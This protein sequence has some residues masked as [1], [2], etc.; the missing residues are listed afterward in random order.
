MYDKPCPLEKVY[1]NV[2]LGCR[3]ACIGRR[4][5]SIF[6]QR[7]QK[8]SVC[9]PAL[10]WK[11]MRYLFERKTGASW[12]VRASAEY[13]SLPSPSRVCVTLSLSP[14]GEMEVG[15]AGIVDSVDRC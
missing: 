3:H 6:T 11:R 1:D 15:S 14:E 4:N 7:R 12:D 5:G 8:R 9:S 2:I 10:Y 13:S